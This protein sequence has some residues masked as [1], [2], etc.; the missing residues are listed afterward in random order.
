VKR[1]TVF[2]FVRSL[3]LEIPTP[4]LL[5]GNIV[6]DL[7]SGQTITGK[8]AQKPREAEPYFTVQNVRQGEGQNKEWGRKE[9][10]EMNV[11][12]DAVEKYYFVED[13]KPSKNDATEK[14]D[15]EMMPES[16]Q[17]QDEV[18]VN[19]KDTELEDKDE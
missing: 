2:D 8:L 9:I 10:A 17:G 19:V 5:P 6:I 13:D 3:F 12:A 4:A 7:K 18:S 11:R 1:K 14:P 16:S 15:Q